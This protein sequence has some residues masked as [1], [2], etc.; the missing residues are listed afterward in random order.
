[1]AFTMVCF[2]FAVKPE[3]TIDAFIFYPSVFGLYSSTSFVQTSPAVLQ[4]I[5][6]LGS[7][8]TKTPYM[9]GASLS[10]LSS[11]NPCFGGHSWGLILL[12]Y[13]L[14][15]LLEHRRVRGFAEVLVFATPGLVI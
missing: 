14:P 11:F 7:S 13:D 10:G 5:T 15:S 3:S 9:K 2:G 12:F 1:M 4:G 8:S 6:L